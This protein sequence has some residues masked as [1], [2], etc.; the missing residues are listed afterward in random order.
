VTRPIVVRIGGREAP[1]RCTYDRGL[2][3]TA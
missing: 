1:Q 3:G 2:R